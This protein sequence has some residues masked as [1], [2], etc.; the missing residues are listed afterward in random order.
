LSKA[1]ELKDMNQ[2]K[3]ENDPDTQRLAFKPSREWILN[4]KVGSLAPDVFN[5]LRR[6]KAIVSRGED[7]R[8]RVYV[9]AH[10]EWD[11]V[12]TMLASYKE[13]ELCRGLSLSSILASSDGGHL[14]ESMPCNI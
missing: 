2:A 4:L 12:L 13:E 14:Q 7:H 1:G 10:L 11:N 8:G 5:R 9:V 6:V 3:F